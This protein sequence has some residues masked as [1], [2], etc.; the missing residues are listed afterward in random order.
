MLTFIDDY[1]K[2]VRVYFL[3]QKNESFAAFK[4][5]KALVEK[6]IDRKVNNDSGLEFYSGKFIKF[7][8]DE[9]IMR[10][11]TVRWTPQWSGIEE[12]MNRTLLEKVWYLLF[13]F[14]LTQD[15]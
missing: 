11:L 1:L 15:F 14:G 13:N 12:R 7:C 5:W 10:C 9:G 3:K 4:Q 2:K 8:K 6:Q